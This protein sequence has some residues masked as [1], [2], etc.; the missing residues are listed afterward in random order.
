MRVHP[1]QEVVCTANNDLRTWLAEW[2]A[3]HQLTWSEVTLLL[4]EELA[5]MGRL[6][7]RSERGEK[8]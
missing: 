4:A 3:R 6:F 1:R 5:G 7:V 2:R 8:L